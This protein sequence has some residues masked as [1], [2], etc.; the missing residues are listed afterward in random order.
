APDPDGGAEPAREVAGATR[1]CSETGGRVTSRLIVY[2]GGDETS[3]RLPPRSRGSATYA[4][5]SL[6]YDC[7]PDPETARTSD[8][9]DC[10]GGGGRA[11]GVGGEGAGRERA[12]RGSPH[13]QRRS[14]RR[15][16][17]VDPGERR[18]N[19]HD[20]RGAGARA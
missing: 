15:R 20:R 18:R 3:P 12:G 2:F 10:G 11:A 17:R 19:R 4:P 13:G 14:A 16:R 6:A 8:Q 9:Q 7:W 5:K 1:W